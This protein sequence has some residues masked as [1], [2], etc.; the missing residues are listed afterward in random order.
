MFGPRRSRI[1]VPPSGT[2]AKV[3]GSTTR[4]DMPGRR[5][6]TVPTRLATC[7]SAVAVR[8]GGSGWLRFETGEVSVS[9]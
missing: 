5:R 1:P 7:G 9:P 4:A 3:S 8:I 2:S 6:P